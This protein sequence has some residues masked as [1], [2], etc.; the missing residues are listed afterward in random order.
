MLVGFIIHWLPSNFKEFY[1]GWFI[2]TPM[3]I[4]VLISAEVIF[5]LYQFQSS[6]IYPFIY[7]QF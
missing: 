7:F 6:E 3:Y 5:L 1:R 2:K 4:K